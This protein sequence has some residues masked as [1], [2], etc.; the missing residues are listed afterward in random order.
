MTPRLS[1]IIATYNREASLVR[2]LEQLASQALAKDL[3]E[4]VVIDDGSAN[5]VAPALRALHPPYALRV[6]RQPNAGAAAARHRGVGLAKG[7]I[8][9]LLDDDMQVGSDLVAAHLELHERDDHAV[10]LG[11]ILPDRDA[12]LELFERFHADVL[13]RFAASVIAGH[14]TA[15]GPNVYSGNV[16]MRR[17]AYERVGG[18]DVA[19]GHSEDAELGVRLEKDGA[20]FYVS[21]RAASIHS[22]DR[23][24]AE[25]WLRRAKAYGVFDTRIA[26][27]HP[28]V[29][30]ASPWRYFRDLS[31]LARPFLT[32]SIGAPA[33][34]AR[35][36]KLALSAA[37]AVDSV[38]LEHAAIRGATLAFG[39][40]YAVGMRSETESL[41]AA[42]VDWVEYLDRVGP[43]GSERLL[44]ALGRLREAIREDH[45][46]L[47]RYDA[48]Y[49]D[50]GISKSDLPKDAVVRI[51][52]QIMVAVRLMHFFR[53]AGA[54]PGAMVVS[55]LIRHL[56]G[57]DIHW[58]ADIAPGVQIVHGMGLAISGKARIGRDV[59]LFQNV[60]LGE[61]GNGAPTIGRSVHIGPGATLLG[62][63][64]VGENTKVMA[65]CIVTESVPADSLVVAPPPDVRPRVTQRKQRLAT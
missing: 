45:A 53:D 17:D 8:I 35:L 14:T 62:P 43:Q 52:F 1:V 3:F 63:I 21:E 32:L 50:R 9:L 13:E 2:L 6:E 11:R 12:K 18:F 10:V 44:V 42:V 61:S 39:L 20:H 36:A 23:A 37:S 5:D 47:R 33:L 65:G 16:S 34:G 30:H 60:T 54:L 46:T 4:V 49:G 26:R 31:P 19:F 58:E 56:Y 64:E 29:P 40:E 38:G 55:R 48:K 27:K 57:A 59:I 7:D 15:R 41:L 25:G 28:D 22:S 24:S 51:G